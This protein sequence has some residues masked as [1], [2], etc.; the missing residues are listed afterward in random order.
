MKITDADIEALSK[1][2]K[3]IFELKRAIENILSGHRTKNVEEALIMVVTETMMQDS[4]DQN[5]AVDRAAFFASQV[6]SFIKMIDGTEDSPWKV[7]GTL[8]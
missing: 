2:I 1:H 5:E 7:K 4:K 3:E 8:Q 6:I